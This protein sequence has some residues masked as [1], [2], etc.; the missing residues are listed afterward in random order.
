MLIRDIEKSKMLGN[1]EFLALKILKTNTHPYIKNNKSLN[2]N[3][4][5]KKQL[6][7]SEE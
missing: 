6:L 1:M 4:I 5:K 3:K 7:T 2:K